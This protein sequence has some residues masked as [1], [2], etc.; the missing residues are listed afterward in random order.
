MKS[1]KI[2][3]TLFVSIY[4]VFLMI[5]DVSAPAIA[6]DYSLVSVGRNIDVIRMSGAI[7][8]GDA[9]K[10]FHFLE[11]K[12]PAGDPNGLIG[13]FALDS[14]GG[15]ILEAEAIARYIHKLQTLTV[16]GDGDVCASACFL[17]F[18]AGKG[19]LVHPSAKIAVHST[20]S[21]NG[22]E[23]PSALAATTAMARDAVELG[24]PKAIIGKIVATPPGKIEFLSRADLL[25]MDAEFSAD[26]PDDTFRR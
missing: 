6:M 15:N 19:K 7:V 16:V 17:L 23:T 26:E 25:S 5:T 20:S 14:P 8:E 10:L 13:G 1:K 4:A 11:N 9:G 12:L 2:V 22:L 18:A 21:A 3:F 24:V